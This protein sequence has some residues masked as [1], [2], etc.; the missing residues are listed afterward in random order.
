MCTGGI[1]HLPTVADAFGGDEIEP[2]FLF[3]RP[4]P[5]HFEAGRLYIVC[6]KRLWAEYMSYTLYAE[7]PLHLLEHQT[8]RWDRHVFR[9]E[10][11]RIPHYRPGRGSIQNDPCDTALELTCLKFFISS[12][13]SGRSTLATM[14]MD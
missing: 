7:N 14:N 8:C 5:R 12:G 3:L 6:V 13:L 1:F 2:L 10:P 9:I 4:L 11:S